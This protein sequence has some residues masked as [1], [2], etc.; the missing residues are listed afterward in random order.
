[1]RCNRSVKHHH[2]SQ[3]I[4]TQLATVSNKTLVYSQYIQLPS[5]PTAQ[6][7]KDTAMDISG[8]AKDNKGKYLKMSKPHKESLKQRVQNLFKNKGNASQGNR[9]THGKVEEFFISASLKK[10]F[11]QGTA[12]HLRVK[13][14]KELCSIV[15]TKKLEDHALETIWANIADILDPC[16]SSEHR[17]LVLHFLKC[18]IIGQFDYLGVMRAVFF[19][20]L[21]GHDVFDDLPQKLDVFKALSDNGKNLEDFEEEAGPFLEK[22]MPDVISYGKT[23]DFLRV[24]VNVI[25]YNACFLD[26]HIIAGFVRHTCSVCHH[27]NLEEE[28]DLA[29][30][31]LDAVVCYSCLPTESLSYFIIALCKTVNIK[32]CCEPT[33]KLMRNLLGTHLGHSAI[34]TMCSLL[35]DSRNVTDFVLLRGAVFF[36]GMALWGS[37]RVNSLKHRFMSVLPSFYTALKSKSIVV[38]YEVA[39]SVQRLVKKYSKEIPQGTWDTILDIIRELFSQ[40]QVPS[41]D[42]EG[43]LLETLNREAQSLLSY[44]ETLHDNHEYDGS[45]IKLFAIVEEFSSVRPESS[46]L[47]LISFRAQSIH[48]T[49]VDWIPNLQR[50]M[51]NFFRKDRP[52][53][54]REK[55]V[56]VLS[57]VHSATRHL[58]EDDL[59]EMVILPQFAHIADDPSFHI[60]KVVVQFLLDIAKVCQMKRCLDVLD[61]IAKVVMNPVQTRDVESP[62]PLGSKVIRKEAELVDIQTGVLGLLEMFKTKLSR[63]PSNHAVAAFE[64]L[65]K[66][67]LNQYKNNYKSSVASDIRARLKADC[68][69]RLGLPDKDGVM[70]YSPY[71][72]CDAGMEMDIAGRPSPPMATSPPLVERYCRTTILPFGQ[73]FKAVTVSLKCELDWHV[74][75]VVIFGLTKALQNKTLVLASQANLDLLCKTM[76]SMIENP[77]KVSSLV[78][79]PSNFHRID[80]FVCVYGLLTALVPYHSQL[81]P[82]QKV[83]LIKYLQSG[84]KLQCPQQCIDGM[85]LCVLEMQDTMVKMLPSIILELSKMSATPSMAVPVLEFLSSLI[86]FPNLYVSFVETAYMSIFAVALHYTNPYKFSLYVVSL[87][88]HVIAMWFIK[89]R[90][91]FRREFVNCITRGLKASCSRP[92]I[93]SPQS[94]SNKTTGRGLRRSNSLTK[95]SSKSGKSDKE[96]NKESTCPNYD[97][98][99]N[100]HAH[101]TET[102]LDMMARFTF[103]T[104][105][106]MPKRSPISEFLLVGGQSQSWLLGNKII[107]ITTSGGSTKLQGNGVCEK[108]NNMIRSHIHGHGSLSDA[109][110]K[111]KHDGTQE[112]LATNKPTR[113]RSKSGDTQKEDQPHRREE[114]YHTDTQ[115]LRGWRA[116][117]GRTLAPRGDGGKRHRIER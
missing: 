53:S 109:S 106:T 91:P 80:F 98:L 101:L 16:V 7:T 5:I 70:K 107:T 105:T 22:W 34:Y 116:D 100:L 99:D 93:F 72:L 90:L 61:I 32:T 57:S 60:R 86:W 74:L 27:T 67:M 11:S 108:C 50:L 63:S 40:M 13:A 52:T 111:V 65:V 4:H 59:L 71:I 8:P 12:I 25:K 68:H 31:V 35:E 45:P 110:N 92:V 97:S 20:V 103:S 113:Q 1:M 19:Q 37:K 41:S 18:L 33:W 47:S 87:A 78:N 15:T 76:F 6:Y 2:R 58:Y 69:G 46:L 10:E 36:V 44:I 29:L 77:L 89:C 94:E 104:C 9:E 26:E 38:A 17:Q 102:C 88:H 75:Q 48:P 117:Q 21:R 95:I 112:E 62:G 49:K 82:T 55:S 30:K 42:Q 114:A 24:L 64:L 3:K 39:L 43:Q 83:A 23:S 85:M 115:T 14:I 66:H 51:E 79:V 28:I 81:E 96:Q 54:V 73:A 56:L 84:L